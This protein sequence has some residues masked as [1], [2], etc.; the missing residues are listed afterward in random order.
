MLVWLTDMCIINV[1]DDQRPLARMRDQSSCDS[2]YVAFRL[3]PGLSPATL[4]YLST[5]ARR[6]KGLVTY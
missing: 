1:Y 6:F 4:A 3:W 5:L 2:G